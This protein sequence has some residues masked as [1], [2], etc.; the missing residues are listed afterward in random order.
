MTYSDKCLE[1]RI[2]VAK[3]NEFF[4]GKNN[5]IKSMTYLNTYS[6]GQIDAINNIYTKFLEGE[7][8]E[9]DKSM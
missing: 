6:Y 9:R 5:F 2:K 4:K 3:L 1:A 7:K 8:N